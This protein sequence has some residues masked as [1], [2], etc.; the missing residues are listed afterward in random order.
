MEQANLESEN[1][2]NRPDLLYS[3]GYLGNFEAQKQDFWKDFARAF[4][5][6]PTKLQRAIHFMAATSF[7]VWFIQRYLGM[8]CR[9]A[10]WSDGEKP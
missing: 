10:A 9:I 1:Y 6:P 2:D 7:G 4:K 8:K 3:M 5:D